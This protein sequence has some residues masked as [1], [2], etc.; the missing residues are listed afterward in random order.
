MGRKLLAA[1]LG[2]MVVWGG[3]T[4]CFGFAEDPAGVEYFTGQDL[5]M[6]Q[7]RKEKAFRAEESKANFT[8]FGG[9]EGVAVQEGSLRF[10]LTDGKATLGWGNYANRQS[11][12]EFKEMW[13]SENEVVLRIR[14]SGGKSTFAVYGWVDNRR[15]GDKSKPVTLEGTDWQELNVGRL[16]YE[17]ETAINP[18][19]FELE[20]TGEKGTIFQVSEVKL[21]Q[22]VCEG[23]VRRE[24]VIPAGKIWRAVADIG[25]NPRSA[26]SRTVPYI[27]GKQVA[28][29]E[30]GLYGTEPVDILPYLRNG[31][32]CIGLYGF[33]VT[34][35]PFLYFQA[36]IIMESGEVIRVVTEPDGS[37]KTSPKGAPG[38]NEPG[39]DDSA[40]SKL[41]KA[42]SGINYQLRYNPKPS[43]YTGRLVIENPAGRYLFYREDQD[44]VF[45][46][47]TPRGLAQ[48]QPQLSYLLARAG[49]DG[50]SEEVARGTVKTFAVKGN[51]LVYS[52]NAGRLEQGVYT[53]ALDLATGDAIIESRAR[54]PFI[55]SRRHG[56]K[57]TPGKTIFDGLDLELEDQVDFTNPNDPHPW[58][59]VATPALR[60]EPIEKITKPTIV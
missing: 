18:D 52:I 21:A 30:S 25:G 17:R 31:S 6:P 35:S 29:G 11:P 24:F 32:N 9:V 41:E 46:V 59:E 2:M 33:R 39:F 60:G 56:E 13:P 4:V 3:Q 12:Q 27:N 36:T 20:I 16:A 15:M 37:W 48:Q 23:Y 34:H 58:I 54:E 1:V 38:W 40:W 57:T 47:R 55:V 53:I 5:Q 50:A 45:E 22:S 19:G 51:S 14:Q 10:T 7:I 49:E 26:S 8:Y 28:K 42:Y 43:G 44:I